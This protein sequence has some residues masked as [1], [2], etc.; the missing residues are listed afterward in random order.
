MIV[1]I[2]C[3]DLSHPTLPFLKR[4]RDERSEDI[5]ILQSP[6]QCRGGDFLFL[7]SCHDIIGPDVRSRYRHSL[8]CHASD[9]PKGRGWSPLVWQ[10][11]EGKREVVVTLLEA[12]DKVDS[13]RIWF[14]KTCH[15]GPTDLFD[16][17]SRKSAVTQLDL[18]T[19]AVDEEASIEPTDQ[20]G[21]PTFYPRRKPSDS[22]IDPHKT[23]AEQ[24]DLIRV[25]DP[26]RYPAFLRYRGEEF[27]L[28]L[29]RKSDAQD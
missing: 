27:V 22:E 8:V 9:L 5:E 21:E 11:I 3:S 25:S 13:G 15:I 12:E 26:L 18:M 29:E 1:D 28:R 2:I 16:E 23:I 20:I 24:F 19:L 10:I 6:S 17:I 7:I 14:K 4:W